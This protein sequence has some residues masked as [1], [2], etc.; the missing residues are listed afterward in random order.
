MKESTYKEYLP[1]IEKV[2]KILSEGNSLVS[3]F[4]DND[5][6]IKKSKF[7]QL[8]NEHEDFVDK[9]A[10]ACEDRSDLLFEEILDI[11]DENEA[12]AYI[13]NG[14][15]KIDGNTV[16]RS[17]LKI[18]SR[19]WMLGKMNPKKYGERIQQDVNIHTEQPLYPDPAADE[20]E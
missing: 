5:L 7:Y 8:L 19:K 9:Y 2:C 1:I 14:E 12:D 20:K 15:A 3:V 6:G 10:R 11:A 17:R 16:Q 13:D 18:E 4:R